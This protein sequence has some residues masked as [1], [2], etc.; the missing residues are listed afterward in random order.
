MTENVEL[1][2]FK[3][4]K[5]L[6][7][8]VVVIIAGVWGYFFP[9]SLSLASSASIVGISISPQVLLIGCLLISQFFLFFGVVR[10]W[11]FQ[12]RDYL[13]IQP[14]HSLLIG[15]VFVFITAFAFNGLNV[16]GFFVYYYQILLISLYTLVS[17]TY[18]PTAVVGLI[19]VVCLALGFQLYK[20]KS[21]LKFWKFFINKNHTDNLLILGVVFLVF[22][23][24]LFTLYQPGYVEE[25][26]VIEFDGI[27]KSID[28]LPLDSNMLEALNSYYLDFVFF[29]YPI[30]IFICGIFLF[31]YSMKKPTAPLPIISESL[32]E[33]KIVPTLKRDKFS[34]KGFELVEIRFLPSLLKRLL[35]K[36]IF[37]LGLGIGIIVTILGILWLFNIDS[38]LPTSVEQFA[39]IDI[40]TNTIINFSFFKSSLVELMIISLLVLLITFIP[41]AVKPFIDERVFRY[42]ARR[43]L[44]MIPMFIGISIISYS[45]MLAT[46][47]P[48]DLIMS[49]QPPGPGRDQLYANLLRIYGLNAPPQSQWFNWFFHFI[50]GDLGNSI[51][52]GRLVTEAI[53]IRLL[54][55]LEI[56]ILPLVLS[57]LIAIPLGIF[58]ALRQYSW[59]DNVI[60]ILVSLGLAVPIF[61]LIILAILAFTYYIPILP[62]GGMTTPWNSA[63][64]VNLLYVDLYF[65]TFIGWLFDWEIWDL[66]FHLVIPVGA[67]TLIS[68]A[69][70]VRLV[71]S[72][73]LEVVRQDFILSAQAYGFDERTIIFRHSLRNV[74]I[75]L[76]TYIGLSI[77]TLLG[78]APLTETTLSWP[79]LGYYGVISIQSYDYP[80]VMGLIMVTAV[81]ILLA[82]L[83]TDLLYSVVDPRVNLD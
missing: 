72:G 43:L 22:M 40:L 28:G 9:G 51:H 31:K 45:L 82:N 46:G 25:A 15:S 30:T 4:Q 70:Y 66:L 54:P 27:L 35:L 1:S 80:V 49:R 2:E 77:G 18:I 57:I 75:P 63:E 12:I 78:G 53:G 7:I 37:I 58:A 6:V 14:K 83:F 44:S 60:A 36:I 38:L 71:R 21:D 67:I 61:L 56:S 50:M 81:L 17:L 39:Q 11:R 42:T 23:Y 3:L 33:A 68:L 52:G 74:L 73:Y 34:F 8:C 69:L 79:G 76:V 62:A 47:N 48:V 59:E 32:K 64:G 16:I 5:F 26:G 65:D 55:T 41:R 19:G 20:K 29:F 24:F 10:E 13:V